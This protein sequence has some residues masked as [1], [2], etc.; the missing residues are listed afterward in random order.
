MLGPSL[1]HVQRRT[2]V[3]S[4]TECH[5]VPGSHWG[6]GRDIG[7]LLGSPWRLTKEE[8]AEVDQ[9]TGQ[10]KPCFTS[11]GGGPGFQSK[12]GPWEMRHVGIFPESA[13][14]AK[15]R[16]RAGVVWCLRGHLPWEPPESTVLLGARPGREF[17]APFHPF[18]RRRQRLREEKGL[19]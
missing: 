7:E 19:V 17:T 4:G 3:T 9:M 5:K 1:A 12:R 16:L 11:T 18:Y 2:Q 6:D 15:S 10:G 13:P 14:P 8:L